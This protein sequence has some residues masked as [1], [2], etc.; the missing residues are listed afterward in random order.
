LHTAHTSY[1][2]WADELGIVHH[3]YYGPS[4]GEADLRC[5]E[6]R[7]DCG[8]S[9]QPAGLDAQ[10]DYSLDTLCQEYTG[11]GVGDYRIGCLRL[12]AAD[13]SRAAD[14]RFAGAEILPGKYELP[15]LPA[16]FDNGGECETLRLTLKDPVTGLTVVLLYGV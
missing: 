12:T 5:L 7:S 1:Q 11:S 16:A 9:P 4:I 3:L 8:F 15:G 10:R 13:G 6:F 14:L 2:L